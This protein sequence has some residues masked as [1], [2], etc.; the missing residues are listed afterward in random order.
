MADRS[1]SLAAF[2]SRRSKDRDVSDAT[3]LSPRPNGQVIWVRALRADQISALDSLEQQLQADG[4]AVSLIVTC[5]FATGSIIKTPEGRTDVGAFLAHW[6]PDLVMWLEA[7]LDPVSF[8]EL[9]ERKIPCMLISATKNALRPA[10]KSWVPGVGRAMFNQCHAIM[11]ADD[12]VRGLFVRAGAD[13]DRV[14]T[15]GPLESAPTPLSHFED[16]RQDLAKTLGSRSIWLAADSPLSE[17]AEIAKA[18]HM[19]SRRAHRLLLI[20][21]LRDPDDGMQAVEILRRAGFNVALR[22]ADEEPND[23]TQVYV[24][25]TEVELG[26][27]YRIAPITYLG[28]TLS[29]G[30]CRD[31][32]EP[33]T[34][35]SAVLHG[36]DVGPFIG[37]IER[38]AAADACVSL[39]SFDALGKTVE[40]LLSPDKTAQLV[41]A[42]W[43]VTSRGADV[44]NRLAEA[45]MAELDRIEG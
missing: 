30:P 32:F 2:F 7:D 21:A 22:T 26:L 8:L 35:G 39:S 3:G 36:P 20:V 11:T 5:P 6:K 40:R 42:A 9:A 28:G 43:D 24:A 27:W 17:I 15:L 23:A 34:L 1:L 45:I 31:P 10:S 37:Q 38:L 14:Q 44:T 13:P 12:D 19:A 18:H 29:G 16:E 25:D 4:D 41:H 33:A